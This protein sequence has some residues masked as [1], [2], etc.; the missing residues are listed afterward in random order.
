MAEEATIGALRKGKK[1]RTN[2]AADSDVYRCFLDCAVHHREVR[3]ASPSADEV[4]R[5]VNSALNLCYGFVHE[6][7]IACGEAACA[8]APDC[9]LAHIV[10]AYALGPNYNNHM[11]PS[12]S[13][14]S[15]IAHCEKALACAEGPL[16]RSLAEA[17]RQRFGDEDVDDASFAAA[18]RAV[19][20]EHPDDADVACIFA[21]A[22]M[23]LRPWDLWRED[24]SARPMAEEARA[25]LE[26]GLEAHAGHPGMLHMYVHLMEM[27][28]DP[29]AALPAADALRDLATDCGHLPHMA[30]HID[31]LVGQWGEAIAANE[32]AIAADEKFVAGR[33]TDTGYSLYRVHDYHMCIYAAMMCGNYAKAKGTCDRM[34]SPEVMVSR[35][36]LSLGPGVD[37][38][39]E[40]F[41]AVDLHVLLRF[42]RWDDVLAY[43]D[44]PPTASLAEG[45]PRPE[46]V[47]L[48]TTAVRHYAR[49]VAFAARRR[50]DEALAEQRLFRAA[51]ERVPAGRYLHLVRCV[52]ALAIAADVLD[53]EVLYAAGEEGRAFAKLRDAVRKSDALQY[54]EPWGW[55]HPPRHA[56]GALLL[57]SGRAEEALAVFEADLERHPANI[58]ALTGAA[59]SL[60]A[61][62]GGCC[63]APAAARLRDLRAAL[64]SAAALADVPVGAACACSVGRW[65]AAAEES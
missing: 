46:D 15:A 24:G 3:V 8:L 37:D 57:E 32:R 60:E 26:R 16:E 21:D 31:V 35:A 44:F 39:C 62:G 49:G 64:Q 19:Y 50:M 52:D 45:D 17:M 20:G 48:N 5:L 58:W 43:P 30:S 56:L 22:L 27:S 34:L 12:S 42:G 61:A 51:L 59:Q 40:A 36:G 18:M 14:A 63:A 65:E 13:V 4:A 47:F 6:E 29:R 10:V 23:N 28:P 2:G 11:V 53:G 38:Y 1:A 54:D 9:A 7:A 55:M 33:G 41:Y 25:V